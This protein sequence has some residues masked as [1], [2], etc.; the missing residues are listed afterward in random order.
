MSFWDEAINV[1]LLLPSHLIPHLV[2]MCL[3]VQTQGTKGPKS[4]FY[5]CK[6]LC[7]I[8]VATNNHA[9]TRVCCLLKSANACHALEDADDTIKKTD[10]WQ[11]AISKDNLGNHRWVFLPQTK[12]KTKNYDHVW[13][14]CNAKKRKGLPK[15]CPDPVLWPP[16]TKQPRSWE[17]PR[18]PPR[19]M[20][21]F[22]L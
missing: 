12:D 16:H 8:R 17:H 15:N 19:L 2:L 3:T 11:P 21:L 13:G 14:N 10:V 9:V 5:L 6:C 1:F 7:C 4:S 20:I 22:Q 18:P